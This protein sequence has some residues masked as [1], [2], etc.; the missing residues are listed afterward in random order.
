MSPRH[1]R[2]TRKK[3]AREEMRRRIVDATLKLHGQ[4]G[5]FGTSWA[6]IAAEADV[7]VG[8]VYKYFPTLDELVPAC[9]E[10]LMERVQPPQPDS[11]GSILGD[12][13]EP[14]ERLRRVA[15]ALFSFYDRGGRHLEADLRERELAAVR[16]WE[17]F[18]RGMAA[19]FVREAL[20]G[21]SADSQL[22]GRLSFLFDF[23]TYSAMRIRGMDTDTAITT[24]TELA[25]AWLDAHAPARPRDS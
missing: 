13:T 17:D 24:A 18:L 11:I 21:H 3:A 2:M 1:Y 22:T 7:S 23:P 15:A 10:L 16:E 4:R 25:I 5:I 14:A 20:A 9:G 19:G 6:D 8:T 12:S